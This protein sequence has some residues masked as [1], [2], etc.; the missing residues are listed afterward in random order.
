ME[1]Q[2]DSPAAAAGLVA[3]DVVTRINGNP[4]RTLADLRAL[5][6]SNGRVEVTTLRGGRDTVIAMQRA[7]VAPQPV[8]V[9]RVDGT[10]VLRVRAFTT[11]AASLISSA[12]EAANVQVG[13]PLVVDLRDNVGGT[14][15]RSAAELFA[16]RGG[17]FGGVR[18]VFGS[19]CFEALQAELTPGGAWERL[20]PLLIMVNDQTASAAE[21][22]ARMLQASGRALVVGPRSHGKATAQSII[23]IRGGF[24]FVLSTEL[25]AVDGSTW[26]E[27][28]LTM[29]HLSIPG[30]DTSL[31]ERA[32]TSWAEYS[33]ARRDA[34]A[35]V[36]HPDFSRHV[37]R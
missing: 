21:A 3:G 25:L 11:D 18:R 8:T 14:D 27:T 28:G 1:V 30:L 13:E 37:G 20:G 6:P 23:P 4:V 15:P 7:I 9:E 2:S 19:P 12:L 33:Q 31:L 36:R 10:A 26:N 17:A 22:F 16:A 34:V 5:P 32:A 35:V 24:D 29:Q